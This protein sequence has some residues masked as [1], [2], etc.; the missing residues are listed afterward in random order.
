M[1]TQD[2][3]KDMV[4]TQVLA[5][6]SSLVNTLCNDPNYEDYLLNVMLKPD[7]ES[8]AYD[9]GFRV[10]NRE[11]GFYITWQEDDDVL[12]DGS[13]LTATDAWEGACDD[14]AIEPHLNVAH[15]HWIVSYWLAE[16]LE[17]RGEMIEYD[18]LGLIIWGRC[19]T[20]QAIYL[21][22]VMVDIVDKN[23]C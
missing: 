7:Y 3:V 20:G 12:E 4:E 17:E 8:A 5:P 6:V 11:D 14:N 10:E 2:Q 22:Q 23:N 16:R 1:A 13:Y 15:E 21:D 19:A 18:F 9:N